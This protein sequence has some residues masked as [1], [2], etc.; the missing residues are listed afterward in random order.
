MRTIV[1]VDAFNLYYGCLKGTPWRWLDLEAL[2]RHLLSAS[3]RIERIKYYTAHVGARRDDPGQVSRQQRYLRALRTLPLV[4][5]H[6]GHYLSHEVMMPLASPPPNGPRFAKVIRTE[7]KGSDVN[8][9]TH[10]VADGYEDRYDAAVIVSND[11][12]LLEPLRLV[13]QRLGK[14]VGVLNP[15]RHPAFVLARA[16]SFFKQIRPSAVRGS[17]FPTT[18]RDAAGEFTKPPGW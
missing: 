3:N 15:Q 14:V 5:I 17:Q 1:Y 16:A 13:R 11:S 9:A 4:E 12:D 18:L 10:L 2:A 8:L 7:E 6:L